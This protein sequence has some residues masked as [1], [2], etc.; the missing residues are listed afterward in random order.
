MR[1]YSTRS[2]PQE[3]T[4]LVDLV[5]LVT[6]VLTQR[7]PED[8]TIQPTG[9]QG[10]RLRYGPDLIVDVTAPD[11]AHTRLIVEAK[12]K[13]DA[14]Q[15]RAAAD[16][17][18][19]TLRELADDG[20]TACGVVVAPYI[21]AANRDRLADR[22]LG[23]VDA[24]GNV[25]LACDRPAIFIQSAGSD[26]NPWPRPSELQSLKGRA[27]GR[28]VRALVDFVPPYGIRQLAKRAQVSAPTLSRVVDLLDREGLVERTSR[29]PVQALDWEGAIRRWVLD[30]GVSD[31]NSVAMYLAPRGP[32]DVANKLR[33]YEGQYAIT[34]SMAL[35]R[36]VSIAPVRLAMIYTLAAPALGPYLGLRPTDGGA[37]VL[38]IEPFDDVVFARTDRRHDLV[39]AA[40]SQLAA[41]LLTGPGRA[42]SEGDELITWM[43]AHEDAWRTRP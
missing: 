32:E 14:P 6:S 30:Y 19:R 22:G 23:F 36:E 40:C 18:D 33:E 10:I 39:T 38:L 21:S 5:S 34:G 26:R 12:R 3:P 9:E 13:L 4:T 16:E 37:N 41:D 43:K 42:P 17:L 1:T 29:G 8:W 35:P 7:L 25:R 11:G 2:S 15:A 20:V 27:A 24:T 28:A 31:T